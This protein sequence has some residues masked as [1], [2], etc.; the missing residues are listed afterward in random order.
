MKTSRWLSIIAI[1]ATFA[2]FW[3]LFSQ[4]FWKELTTKRIALLIVGMIIE[5]A[6]CLANSYILIRREIRCRKDKKEKNGK[7]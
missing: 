5:F 7:S 1:V 4:F 2:C 3:F 6:L